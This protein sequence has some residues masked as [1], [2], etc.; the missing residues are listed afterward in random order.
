VYFS[1]V[2][3]APQ[4]GHAPLTKHNPRGMRPSRKMTRSQKKW[5]PLHQC[6]RNWA[7]F[8]TSQSLWLTL[9]EC[10]IAPRDEHCEWIFCELEKCRIANRRTP[11]NAKPIK[12]KLSFLLQ[13]LF[14]TSRAMALSRVL[15]CHESH[16]VTLL[17]RTQGRAI[18][19]QHHPRE[20]HAPLTKDNARSACT[21]TRSHL[22]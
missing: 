5:K 17:T 18:L 19:P 9:N 22:D 14:E 15:R 1:A 12:G 11:G 21:T 13:S 16:G 10:S 20:G 2:T 6:R 4:E 7:S 3:G 8:A